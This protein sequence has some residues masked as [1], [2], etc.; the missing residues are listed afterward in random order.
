MLAPMFFLGAYPL[1]GSLLFIALGTAL[2]S[3]GTV[4]VSRLPQGRSILGR[5]RCPRCHKTLSAVELVPFLSY[6][7][8]RGRCTACAGRIPWLYPLLE[9][10]TGILFLLALLREGFWFMPALVLGVALWLYLSVTIMDA[11][12]GYISDYLSFPFLIFS[13]VYA[14]FFPPLPLIAPFLGGAFFALQWGMSRGRWVGSGD[15][16]IG[17]G[18]GFLLRDWRLLVVALFVA[19]IIGAVTAFALI[20][21]KKKTVKDRLPFVP[22]LFIATMVTLLMGYDILDWYIF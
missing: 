7:V 9:A 18:M 14:L 21:L 17:A 2:G 22:F 10:C 11:Q 16:I 5:S 20:L 8:Q 15:I 19:Y 12:T 13:I 4:L 1:L 6:I 3:F